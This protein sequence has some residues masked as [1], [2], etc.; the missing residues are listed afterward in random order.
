M[1][2][3]TPFGAFFNACSFFKIGTNI[4]AQGDSRCHLLR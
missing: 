1:R 4:L 2:S 3:L